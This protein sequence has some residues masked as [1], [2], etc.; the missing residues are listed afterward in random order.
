[1]NKYK[2]NILIMRLFQF[3][4]IYFNIRNT[5]NYNWLLIYYKINKKRYFLIIITRKIIKKN[6]I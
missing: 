3:I 1:M 5:I 6:I 4:P 2:E